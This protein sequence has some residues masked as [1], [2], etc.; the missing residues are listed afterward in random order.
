MTAVPCF[1]QLTVVPPAGALSYVKAKFGGKNATEYATDLTTDTELGDEP[2]TMGVTA[3]PLPVYSRFPTDDMLQC[4]SLAESQWHRYGSTCCSTNL[5]AEMLAG[6]L[7]S[8]D[9]R[10]ITMALQAD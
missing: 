9:A 5:R 8:T 10:G 3:N 6:L 4:Q 2:T 7:L 1:T